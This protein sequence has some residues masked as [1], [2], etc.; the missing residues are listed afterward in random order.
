MFGSLPTLW[1]FNISKCSFSGIELSYFSLK[2][3]HF[4]RI[5]AFATFCSV[6]KFHLISPLFINHYFF[7]YLVISYLISLRL[8]RK[9]NNAGN[10]VIDA[11]DEK[12]IVN[13]MSQPKRPSGGMDE[14][15]S[16]KKPSPTA[17]AL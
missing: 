3:A 16:T 17:A 14:N 6:I 5:S 11:V 7:L 4:S 2:A 13:A 12:N 15:I 9:N 1:T 8:S 10:I